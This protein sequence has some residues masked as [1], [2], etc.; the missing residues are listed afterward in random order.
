VISTATNTVAATIP[1]GS[2]PTAFGLFIQPV[3]TFAGTLGAAN[4]AGTSVAAVVQKYGD[5]RAAADALG[6]PNVSA[7]Q[8]AIRAFCNGPGT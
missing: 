5:V 8:E 3:P 4:C 2:G 7:L 6:V 1:V